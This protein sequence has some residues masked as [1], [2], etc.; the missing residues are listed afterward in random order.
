MVFVVMCKLLFPFAFDFLSN[1][2]R[3]LRVVMLVPSFV[4]LSVVLMRIFIVQK[5]NVAD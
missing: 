2:S 4:G 3:Q 1:L 5:F